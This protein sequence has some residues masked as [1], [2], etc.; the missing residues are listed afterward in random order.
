MTLRR[1][2]LLVLAVILVG[3]SIL[4]ASFLHLIPLNLFSVPQK[5]SQQPQQM[6]EYYV[7]YDEKTG[8]VLMYVPLVVNV[9]DEL[10]TEDDKRYEVVKVE[11]NRAYARF[12][13]DMADK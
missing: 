4:M 2:L 8:Q 5:P 3:F 7:I 9:G 11:E 13:E 1:R 6:H 12:V 10:L